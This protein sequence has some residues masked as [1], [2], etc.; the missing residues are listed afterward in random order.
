MM[1]EQVVRQKVMEPT[2]FSGHLAGPFKIVAPLYLIALV[3]IGS[4][5]DN[6][7]FLG[8][9]AGVLLVPALLLFWFLK[10]LMRDGAQ[11][12]QVANMARQAKDAMV[13]FIGS[14]PQHMD[15]FGVGSRTQPG[16][17]N[18]SGIAFDG[19]YIYVMDDGEIGK[20]PWSAVREW[21]WSIEGY[22]RTEVFAAGNVPI[23]QK[24]NAQVQANAANIRASAQAKAASGFFL[25]V[26]DV[27]KQVWQFTCWDESTLLRWMEIF[28]QIKEGR[29]AVAS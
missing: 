19:R 25:T 15:V 17:M 12:K 24:L 29:L 23:G 10:T 11:K 27:D 20:I 9:F 22:D 5:P 18:G 6:R 1:S 13:R 2:L 8:H 16:Y 28:R 4:R 3:A 7:E 26:A 21:R 14:E